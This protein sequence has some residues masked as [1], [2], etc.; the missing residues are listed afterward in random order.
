M[1]W[2]NATADQPPARRAFD[3]INLTRL[4]TTGTAGLA[5]MSLDGRYVAHVS[6]RDGR[7]GLWLRQIATT[8]NV[9]IVPAADARYSGVTFTP[10][11]NHIYYS[12]Y[13]RGKNIGNLYQIG[14]LGG[15]AR[16]ILEDVDTSV[17]F[18]PDGREFEDIRNDTLASS[19]TWV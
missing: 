9:E 1:W 11:G 13:E 19:C 7:Q 14:V 2:M 18:S 17:S 4:T 6:A 15:G 8:S 10:D 16:L 3:T 12:Y 5:A